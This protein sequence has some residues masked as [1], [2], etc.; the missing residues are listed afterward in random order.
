MKQLISSRIREKHIKNRKGFG[1]EKPILECAVSY[2]SGHH[3]FRKPH[4]PDYAYA[5]TALNPKTTNPETRI[6]LS[7]FLHLPSPW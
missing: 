6:E 3:N 2:D 4:K 5:P 1:E 7:S